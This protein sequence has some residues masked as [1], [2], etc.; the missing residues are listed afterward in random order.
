MINI[1]HQAT[2]LCLHS[3]FSKPTQIF[4]VQIKAKCAGLWYDTNRC[5]Q[6]KNKPVNEVYVYDVAYTHIAIFQL[7]VHIV[8]Y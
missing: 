7:P 6:R 1:F 4:W 5:G 3:A 2:W 8:I